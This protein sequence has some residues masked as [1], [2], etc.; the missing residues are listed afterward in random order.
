MRAVLDWSY[1]LL[2]EDEQQFFRALGI[3]AGG[4]TVEAAAAVAMNA[5]N[6][7]V[8]AI[9]RL[10]DLVAKSLVVADVS[11]ARPHFRLLDTIRAYALEK[12]DETGA[13]DQ[14]ARRHAGYCRDLLQRSGLGDEPRAED[15]PHI[16]D[17]RAALQWARSPEGDSR[18]SIELTASAIPLWVDL[19]LMA[20]CRRH[21]QEAIA[22][23]PFLPDPDPRH[24][25]RL[26]AALGMSLNY[27]TGPVPATAAAWTRTLEIATALP[28]VEYRLRALRGL[29]AH[30]MNASEYR[31]ALVLA[32][33]FQNLAAREGSP[34]DQD[35]GH[36]MAALILHYLGQQEEARRL[37]EP[38]L[39]RRVAP[40]RQSQISRFLLDQD[41]TEQ[42]LLSRILWIQGFP[43]QAARTAQSGIERAEA[44]GHALSLC[45]ALAQGACPITLYNG[46][47]RA[48]ETYVARLLDTALE[49]GLAGWTARGHCFQGVLSIMQDR[50]DLGLRLLQSALDELRQSGA[51]PAHP[52]FLG[53]LAQGLGRVGRFGES[54]QT[55]E[56]ALELCGRSEEHWCQPELLRIKGELLICQAGG[57]TGAAEDC[58]ARAVTLARE[59]GA[60]SW[61]LR[62]ALSLARLRIG[63][64]RPTEARQ[65]L[66]PVHDRFTE[67]FD[68]A[69]LI[70]AKKL[71]GELTNA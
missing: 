54:L 56:Q 5:A 18:M 28:N 43:N 65:V 71:L 46:D 52:A 44:I 50:L 69:D 7:R 36:R 16:D 39:D 24:E 2:S 49:L 33:E 41:V 63:Q 35:F 42:A 4:F 37:L 64:D 68:T 45:H 14:V 59:Q 48:A 13:R 3:F 62:L 23:L 9:D 27:T 21:V 15:H 47:L 32:H 38:R 55:V 30:H 12:L 22:R 11:G 60:L 6:G 20:E 40:L 10:A 1:G 25:M 19:S 29:W 53:A 66:A 57:G 61:E 8:D 67:G 17:L 26:Q 51:A 31:R 70:A 58:L 34:A